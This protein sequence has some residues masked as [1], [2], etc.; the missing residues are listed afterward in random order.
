MDC[1]SESIVH[2]YKCMLKK[3]DLLRSIACFIKIIATNLC[4]V[5][6]LCQIRYTFW[7]AVYLAKKSILSE[8]IMYLSV[9][10]LIFALLHNDFGAFLGR[11]LIKSTLTGLSLMSCKMTVFMGWIYLPSS[12]SYLNFLKRYTYRLGNHSGIVGGCSGDCS[13]RRNH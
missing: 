13:L 4:Y 2:D 10:L 6:M 3:N 9:S 11:M 5:S 8:Q 1:S 7:A 12:R